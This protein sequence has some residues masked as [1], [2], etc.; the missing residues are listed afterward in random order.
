MKFRL[1]AKITVL[2][3]LVLFFTP[4]IMV[5][6]SELEVE[7]TYSGTDLMV[8]VYEE[9][10]EFSDTGTVDYDEFKY[11]YWLIVAFAAGIVT[12][13]VLFIK[14]KGIIAAITS[15]LS[16]IFLIVFRMTFVSFYELEEVEKY[17]VIKTKWGYILCL[18]FMLIT[19]L[20]ALLS[21]KSEKN[22]Y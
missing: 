2:V 21:Y 17:I 9:D 12:L 15:L 22:N 16:S 10:D 14:G 4:F 20:C 5:S 6:C 8:R 11:N 3:A 1:V 13:A 7:E 19:M 18:T